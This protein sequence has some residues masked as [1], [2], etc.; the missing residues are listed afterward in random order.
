MFHELLDNPQRRE[1]GPLQAFARQLF[2]S[3]VKQ[4]HLGQRLPG[5]IV[6]DRGTY[7]ILGVA[8]YAPNELRLLDDVE[9][10]HP[11]WAANV[12]VVVFDVMQ[13]T[14]MDEMRRYVPPFAV[15]SQT[16]VVAVWDRG[17]RVAAETGLRQTREALQKAGVLT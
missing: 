10:A 6:P 16:P 8:S 9:A 5:S 1:P 3:I 7:V 14:D 13:C 4:S 12:T 15:V 17:K 2:P 11:R